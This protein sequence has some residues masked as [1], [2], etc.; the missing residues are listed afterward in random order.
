MTLTINIQKN[1][2]KSAGKTADAIIAWVYKDNRLSATA[3]ELDREEN[4][5][6]QYHLESQSKFTGKSG[7]ILSLTTSKDSEYLRIILVGLGDVTKLNT[8]SAEEAGQKL[9]AHLNEAGC[10]TAILSVQDDAAREEID[11]ADMAAHIAFGMELKTYNF[12]KYKT[13]SGASDDDDSQDGDIDIQIITDKDTKAAAKYEKL[14]AL[15]KGIHLARDLINEPPNKLYPE[16]F[17]QMVKD[18]LKPLGVEIE[19]FDEKKLQ[20]LGFEAHLAVG[21]GSENKPYALIMRWNGNKAAKNSKPLAFVGKG[22]TFDT[23]GINIKP[24]TGLE[25]MKIDMAGGAAVVG[26]IKSLAERKANV[27]VVGIVGL[28]EN[29]PSSSAYLPSDIIGSLSG[30]TIEV[31]NTDAE[32]RLVLA[33]CLTYIQNTYDPHMVI[34]LATLTGAI[35]VALG[36]EYAGVF[37]NDDDLW[38]KL[39]N[40]SKRSGEKLWRMPLDKEFSKEMKS[41]VADLKNLGNSRFAGASTAAAFLEYFIDEGRSWAHIDIAGMTMNNK[42]KKSRIAFGV[43]VLEDLVTSYYE[44]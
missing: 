11:T 25:A 21:M 1:P 32:G 15:R 33:D 23:G 27:N 42:D 40:S 10:K 20:K 4:G 35:L 24:S 36:H 7:Q 9:Y 38:Q 43:R 41:P 6:I 44:E 16:S 37:S 28:A 19:I 8:Q 5:F 2:S 34:D 22:V 13:K 30:K 31:L 12:E 14:V 39:E 18:E 17:A 26:L 29:M 3:E